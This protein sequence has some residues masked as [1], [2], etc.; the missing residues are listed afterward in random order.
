MVGS[1]HHDYCRV[2][3]KTIF[4][5]VATENEGYFKKEE[6]YMGFLLANGAPREYQC[7]YIKHEGIIIDSVKYNLLVRA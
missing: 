2:R 7:Q 5:Q 3:W 1:H 6:F 4:V